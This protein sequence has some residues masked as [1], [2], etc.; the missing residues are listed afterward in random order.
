MIPNPNLTRNAYLTDGDVDRLTVAIL[1]H[2][3]AAERL[4]RALDA[5]AAAARDLTNREETSS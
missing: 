1:R 5:L 4:A 2:D 3:L